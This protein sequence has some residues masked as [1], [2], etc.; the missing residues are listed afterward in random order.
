MKPAN[1]RYT[2]IK[3]E[4][5]LVLGAETSIL[6]YEGEDL[7]IPMIQFDFCVISDIEFK[8]NGYAVGKYIL[9]H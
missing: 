7:H 2:T 3:H 1:K 4:Y 5:E 8:E 9:I 6:R